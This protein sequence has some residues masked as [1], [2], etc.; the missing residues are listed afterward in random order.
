MDALLS[1]IYDPVAIFRSLGGRLL[2]HYGLLDLLCRVQREV[3]LGDVTRRDRF[4]FTLLG[5]VD[6]R[7]PPDLV[8]GFD[9]AHGGVDVPT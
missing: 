6:H 5:R 2:G 4:V 1:G 7:R 3:A 8:E 9:E